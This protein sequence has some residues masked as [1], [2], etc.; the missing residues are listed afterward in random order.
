[1]VLG[2]LVLLEIEINPV[3]AK[4]IAGGLEITAVH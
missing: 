4:L 1:M 2:D 3:M